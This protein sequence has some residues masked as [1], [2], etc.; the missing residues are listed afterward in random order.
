VLYR[1][2][3]T[4]GAPAVAATPP[5]RPG[6]SRSEKHTGW[7]VFVAARTLPDPWA[8]LDRSRGWSRTS[9]LRRGQRRVPRRRQISPFLSNFV[10]APKRL[11]RW[12]CRH[13]S[14]RARGLAFAGADP[15]RTYAFKGPTR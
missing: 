13:A 15:Q 1:Q 10:D 6:A 3:P 14:Q 12:F 2:Y 9:N 5:E 11:M 7:G 8:T 4:F